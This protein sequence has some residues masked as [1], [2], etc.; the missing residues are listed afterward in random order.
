MFPSEHE[1]R[2]TTR[3]N[4][5]G[6]ITPSRYDLALHEYLQK[7]HVRRQSTGNLPTASLRGSLMGWLSSWVVRLA[8]QQPADDR[9]I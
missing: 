9:A 5:E 2:Y 6:G 8:S 3:K 7:Q 1:T 4:P